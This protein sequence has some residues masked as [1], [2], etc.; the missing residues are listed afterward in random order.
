MSRKGFTADWTPFRDA[1]LGRFPGL[2]EADLA[3]ADGSISA[4]ATRLAR[5]DGIAPAEAEQMLNAFSERPNARRCLCG[6]PA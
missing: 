6:A 5:I 2:T 3:D 1:L 4:L